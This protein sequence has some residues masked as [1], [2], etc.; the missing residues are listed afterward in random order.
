MQG[1]RI[2]GRKMHG[3]KPVHLETRGGKTPRQL[4]WEAIRACRDGFTD[5]CLSQA[6]KVNYGTTSAF[7]CSLRNGGYLGWLD[8]HEEGSGERLQTLIKDNGAEAPAIRRDGSRCNKHLGSEAMWRTLRILG[9]ASAEELASLASAAAPVSIPR[10]K[11]YLNWLTRAGYL[12]AKRTAG[13]STRYR[14]IPSRYSGPLPPKIQRTGQVYDPN[15]GK[16]VW[17]TP[18]KEIP[19]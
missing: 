1:R 18:P 17:R 12:Q 9:E 10:A 8:A 3:R 7:T 4:L 14:L 15:L 16:V 6:T 5:H 2:P 13:R 11:T 19:V